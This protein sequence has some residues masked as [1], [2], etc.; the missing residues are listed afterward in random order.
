MAVPG[1]AERLTGYV[2]GGISPFGQR[3]KLPVVVDS[4]AQHT[5]RCTS[6]VGGEGSR[7]RCRPG[8]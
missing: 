6:A 2:V 5:S 4:T 1:D 7:S 8:R 3:R